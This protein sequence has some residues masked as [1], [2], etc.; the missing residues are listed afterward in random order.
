MA[1][2]RASLRACT[3]VSTSARRTR[4]CTGSRALAQAW[5]TRCRGQPASRRSGSARPRP[6]PHERRRPICLGGLRRLRRRQSLRRKRLLHRTA[7][8]PGCMSSRPSHPL[9]DQR[10]SALRYHPS[11]RDAPPKAAVVAAQWQ[12]RLQQ[13]QE[14]PTWP[15]HRPQRPARPRQTQAAAAAAGQRLRRLCASRSP[16]PHTSRHPSH[17]RQWPRAHSCRWASHPRPPRRQSSSSGGSSWSTRAA[18]PSVRRRHAAA[19]SATGPMR[20]F[21]GVTGVRQARAARG[22]HTAASGRTEPPTSPRPRC[23]TS[24]RSAAC[25]PRLRGRIRRSATARSTRRLSARANG[26]GRTRRL[27]R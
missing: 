8:S 25:C 4:A 11:R 9:S 14:Q 2:S 7:C 17:S 20:T 18:L 15:H 16:T 10:A 26:Q 24:S 12:Q 5:V 13:N 19:S 3:V 22:R 1:P 21:L 27:P 23:S 6:S